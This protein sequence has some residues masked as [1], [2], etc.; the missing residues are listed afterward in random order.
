LVVDV[1]EEF[2]EYQADDELRILQ[3]MNH[4]L[5]EFK[6]VD[7]IKL[8]MIGYELTE[9]SVNGTPISEGNSKANGINMMTNKQ[10]NLLHSTALI[11][12]LP[13]QYEETLYYVPVTQYYHGN[14]DNIFAEMVEDLVMPTG[15]KSQFMQVFNDGTKLLNEPSL[16]D[17]VLQ[18]EFSEDIL[19]EKENGVIADEVMETLVRTLTEQEDVE[20]IEVTVEEQETLINETGHMYE[21]PV[22]K[23]DFIQSEKM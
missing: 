23:E 5:T 10:T 12:I 7:K 9:M 6:D 17:G 1:A 15:S 11:K 16:D 4:T 3:A 14:E 21:E 18:L 8:W 19:H 22:T 20:A 2:K 13:K